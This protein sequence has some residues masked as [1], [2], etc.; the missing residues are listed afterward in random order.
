MSLLDKSYPDTFIGGQR[1]REDV[2]NLRVILQG[3]EPKGYS[4]EFLRGYR[5]PKSD[6]S[7]NFSGVMG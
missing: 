7:F 4:E 6:D 3:K 2:D 5:N 1:C